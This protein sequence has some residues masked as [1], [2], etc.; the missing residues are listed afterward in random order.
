[1]VRILRRLFHAVPGL[2]QRLAVADGLYDF[3]DS[4]A[5]LRI[6][7]KCDAKLP[8]RRHLANPAPLDDRR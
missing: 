8:G 1:M 2:C 6:R 7:R 5:G 3:A 4:G